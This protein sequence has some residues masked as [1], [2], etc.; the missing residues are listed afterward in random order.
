MGKVNL[1]LSIKRGAEFDIL[2][3][4]LPSGNKGREKVFPKQR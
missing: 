3:F 1:F 2:F 4:L